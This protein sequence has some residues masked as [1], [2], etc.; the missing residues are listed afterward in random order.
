MYRVI[1]DEQYSRIITM[2][3]IRVGKRIRDINYNKKSNT[4][5]LALENKNGD[6]GLLSI[7][8]A[9]TK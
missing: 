1:F 4:F 7:D 6:I 3:K 8:K 2:E 9:Y 5:S